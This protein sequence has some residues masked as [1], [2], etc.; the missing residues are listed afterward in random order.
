MFKRPHKTNN[1]FMEH[2]DW[3]MG[4]IDTIAAKSF[5]KHTLDLTKIFGVSVNYALTNNGELS[6]L[7]G[8]EVGH[9]YHMLPTF[10]AYNVQRTYNFMFPTSSYPIGFYFPKNNEITTVLGVVP[11]INSSDNFASLLYILDFEI[12]QFINREFVKYVL[13]FANVG[14]YDQQYLNLQKEGSRLQKMLVNSLRDEGTKEVIIDF[15]EQV[16]TYYKLLKGEPVSNQFESLV[17]PDVVSLS[18]SLRTILENEYVREPTIRKANEEELIVF[19]KPE[20]SAKVRFELF[21]TQEEINRKRS[22]NLGGNN[23]GVLF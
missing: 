16:A 6:E 11:T 4:I 3:A 20:T 8:D 7:A 14:K 21:K 15:E 13:P 5:S 12:E 22:I 17:E 19:E 1:K 9:Y 23:T 18:D 2:E 10:L